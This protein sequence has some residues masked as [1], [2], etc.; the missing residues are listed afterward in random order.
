MY[1]GLFF[2]I[3]FLFSCGGSDKLAKKDDKKNLPETASIIKKETPS[4]VP[5][6]D[7]DKESN[8]YFRKDVSDKKRQRVIKKI[9][10]GGRYTENKSKYKSLPVLEKKD[11]PFWAEYFPEKEVKGTVQVDFRI[12]TDGKPDIICV[13]KGINDSVDLI[14]AKYVSEYKFKAAIGKRS[15]KVVA[16]WMSI[17]NQY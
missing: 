10:S 3:L 14:V 4:A 12:S 8:V 5:G 15:G 1:R 7:Y 2:I 6:F 9:L 16:Y 17:L 11:E 13:R